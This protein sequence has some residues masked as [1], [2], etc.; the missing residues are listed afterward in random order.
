LH[1]HLAYVEF[2][3]DSEF[4]GHSSHALVPPIEY[5]PASHPVQL[6]DPS[7]DLNPATQILHVLLFVAFKTGDA[8]PGWQLVHVSSVPISR[9]SYFPAAHGTHPSELENE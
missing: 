5:H 3:S 9:W 1:V 4:R 6:A 7:F 2:P 8:Y